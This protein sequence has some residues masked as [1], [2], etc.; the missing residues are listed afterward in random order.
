MARNSA[1]L[2]AALKAINVER[3]PA[4]F[5]TAWFDYLLD[6]QHKLDESWKKL[7]RVALNY[8]VTPVR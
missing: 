8:G 3:C 2:V 1:S 4:D 6:T 5:R 7:E